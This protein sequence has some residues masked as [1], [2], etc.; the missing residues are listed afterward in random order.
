MPFAKR[1][2]D[3]RWAFAMAYITTGSKRRAAEL[4][5]VP[6]ETARHWTKAEWWPEL[7][8]TVRER[9]TDHLDGRITGIIDTAYNELADR[10][11]K[12]DPHVL[13]DGTV[14]RKPVSSGV[15]SVI[16]ATAVDKRQILRGFNKANVAAKN[17]PKQQRKL[18]Q[19]LEELGAEE[20]KAAREAEEATIQ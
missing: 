16:A 13:K 7:L 14:I 2:D 10:L 6:R 12:G 17:N 8:E 15:L 1:S 3:D 20:K 5:G 11:T 9:H 18:L 4:A 19:Q